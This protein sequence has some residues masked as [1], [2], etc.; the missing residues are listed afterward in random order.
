MTL[1]RVPLLVTSL[2][3]TA[4]V[5]ASAWAVP[6]LPPEYGLRG[7]RRIELAFVEVSRG[8]SIVAGVVAGDAAVSHEPSAEARA[9]HELAKESEC[10]AIGP[11]L[12]RM[13]IEIVDRCR[14]DD[15]A[16]GK[17]FLTMETGSIAGSDDRTYLVGIELTQRLQLVRD[18]KVEPSGATTWSEHRFGIVRADHSATITSCMQLRD[19]ANWFSALWKGGNK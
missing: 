5:G 14:H 12:T 8:P 1:R 10:Q 17:L 11:A 15:A 3:F 9:R 16:C 7:L 2:A 13:G 4:V 6:S 19:L 18:P